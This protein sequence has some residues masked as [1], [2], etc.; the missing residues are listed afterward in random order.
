LSSG[1]LPGSGFLRGDQ[2]LSLCDAPC[3]LLFLPVFAQTDTSSIGG[4][5]TDPQNTAIPGVRIHLRNLSTGAEPYTESGA[6]GECVF[7]LIPA[8]SY[9]IEASTQGFRSF[10]DTGFSVDVA[11]PAYLDIGL[12]VGEVSE[13]VEVVADV[14]MLNTD[15]AAQGTVIIDEKIQSLPLI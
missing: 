3:P 14:S 11:A 7:T 4:R 6:N 9:D 10:H 1:A 12:E 15:S 5:V 2:I 13:R 8:G